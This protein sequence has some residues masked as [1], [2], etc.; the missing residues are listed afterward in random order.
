MSTDLETSKIIY[1]YSDRSEPSMI[2]S[3]TFVMI[4]E[5][6]KNKKAIF[7]RLNIDRNEIPE[8]HD[9]GIPSMVILKSYGDTKAENYEGNWTENDMKEWINIR[10]GGQKFNWRTIVEPIHGD[11]PNEHQHADQNPTKEIEQPEEPI[12]L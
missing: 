9:I 2:I 3:D 8:L 5:V 1:F 4:A 10:T 12:D 7:A 6:F 11:S